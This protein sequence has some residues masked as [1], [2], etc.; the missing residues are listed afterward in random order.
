MKAILADTHLNHK[1]VGILNHV[2]PDARVF[3]KS[4]SWRTFHSDSVLVRRGQRGYIAVALS[5]DPKG[6]RWLAEIIWELN[7]LIF[8]SSS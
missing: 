7:E 2:N 5:D 3:R 1:F 4:G 6:A 8:P